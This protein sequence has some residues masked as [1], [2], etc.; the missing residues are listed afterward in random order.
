MNRVERYLTGLTDKQLI[1]MK[2]EDEKIRLA[3]IISSEV[4]DGTKS[5]VFFLVMVAGLLLAFFLGG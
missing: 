1:E 5:A 2:H 3:S 4:H